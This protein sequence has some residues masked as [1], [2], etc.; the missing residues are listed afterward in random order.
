MRNTDRRRPPLELRRETLRRLTAAELRAVAGASQ[1][2]MV[3]QPSQTC[4]G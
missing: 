4:L 2:C 3:T 1:K